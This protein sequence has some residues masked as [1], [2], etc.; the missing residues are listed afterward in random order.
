[1]SDIGVFLL[2]LLGVGSLLMLVLR[3]IFKSSLVFKSSSLIL[4]SAVVVAFM[5]FLIG[6]NG[7][8]ELK[9]VLPIG[10]VYIVSVFSLVNK[11]IKTPTSLLSNNITQNLAMGKLN[12]A[13]DEKLMKLNDEYGEVAR[14]LEAMRKQLYQT[15]GAIKEV[16]TFINNSSYQQSSAS[17][18]ISSGANEQ[19]ATTEEIS[20][21]MAEISINNE[22]NASNAQNTARIVKDTAAAMNEMGATSEISIRSIN[23]IVEKI[24]IIN[25][26]AYQ[27][28]ILALNASVE[29]ARAGEHGRGF[30]VIANEV[31]M[32][33]EN[34]KHAATEIHAISEE[35]VRVSEQTG[36]MI[37]QLVADMN[38]IT[39]MV[40]EISMA[41]VEQNN[42]LEQ[43]NM[44]IH[45][46]NDVVQQNASSSEE[47]A[48]SSE[49]LTHFSE[50]LK[51]TVKYFEL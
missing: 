17:T 42:S 20:S 19:A 9:Y 36:R 35:T 10:L 38:Q 45:Q 31:R 4:V 47:M 21:T 12:H 8:T 26:I 3:I 18:Q 33:A 25:D 2:I 27:T 24:N 11:S 37:T 28:N 49:E 14:S 13:F 43:I 34:S 46:L 6:K 5:G 29:A 30:S 23:N 22:K 39:R 48:A 51:D 44:A 7:F 41:S 1:M 50:K 40:D 16:S 32:L 15:V